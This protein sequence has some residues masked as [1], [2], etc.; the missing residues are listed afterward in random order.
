MKHTVIK[1]ANVDFT[2]VTVSMTLES[3]EELNALTALVDFSL[4]AG[5]EVVDVG[6]LRYPTVTAQ[7]I[8]ALFP[9]EMLKALDKTR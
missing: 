5:L 2:P 9:I 1:G 3:Q 8:D 7:N 6:R 4:A